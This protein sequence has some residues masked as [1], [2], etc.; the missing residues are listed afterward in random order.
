MGQ[1]H[2]SE[3]K[4]PDVFHVLPSNPP[5]CSGF[6]TLQIRR[7]ILDRPAFLSRSAIVAKNAGGNRIKF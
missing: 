1:A 7:L 5:F 4:L 3:A 2:G 6:S